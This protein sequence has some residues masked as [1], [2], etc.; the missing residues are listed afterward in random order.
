V[1]IQVGDLVKF[2]HDMFEHINAKYFLVAEVTAHFGYEA[3]VRLHGS[4][5]VDFRSSRF[6]V[7]SRGKR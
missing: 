4:G 7:V 6:V 2:K 5:N 3:L 1:K